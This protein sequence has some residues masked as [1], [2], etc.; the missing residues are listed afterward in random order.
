MPVT[1]R[2]TWTARYIRALPTKTV[3]ETSDVCASEVLHGLGKADEQPLSG[4]IR[5]RLFALRSER[6]AARP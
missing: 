1:H 4:R 3:L 2:Q 6:L 5:A